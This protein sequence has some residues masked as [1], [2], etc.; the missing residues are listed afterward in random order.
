MSDTTPYRDF[1]EHAAAV[2]N[3]RSPEDSA[4]A[5]TLL[6]IDLARFAVANTDGG[7]FSVSG[8]RVVALHDTDGQGPAIAVCDS[9]GS[10]WLRLRI[11]EDDA[12]ELAAALVRAVDGA[13]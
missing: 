2:D 13:P 11:T 8:L 3:A 12:R 7:R 6:A 9:D 5:S 1:A 10:R 4:R